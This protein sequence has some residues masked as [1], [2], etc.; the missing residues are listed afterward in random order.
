MKSS[1]LL[2]LLVLYLSTHVISNPLN[3]TSTVDARR[4]DREHATVL[5]S[6]LMDDEVRTTERHRGIHRRN[7]RCAP[8]CQPHHCCKKSHC[9]CV[10]D[11]WGPVCYCKK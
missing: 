8:A 1:Q 4:I 11:Y 3:H 2:L 9:L 5:S 6:T 7:R 10:Q